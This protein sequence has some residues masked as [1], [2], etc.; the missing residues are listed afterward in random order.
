MAIRLNDERTIAAAELGFRRI[1][2]DLFKGRYEFT[3][4]TP[5]GKKVLEVVAI[6]DEWLCVEF[7]SLQR[8]KCSV[9][10]VSKGYQRNGTTLKSAASDEVFWPLHIGG[11]TL[12]ELATDIVK[13]D[14][15]KPTKTDRI[16]LR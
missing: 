10:V 11:R 2:E 12:A 3:V 16:L 13:T 15:T 9:K 6:H 7:A 1:E 5:R 14:Y 8:D 4:Q